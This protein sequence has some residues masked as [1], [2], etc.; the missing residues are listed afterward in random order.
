MALVAERLV[1]RKPELAMFDQALTDLERGG[2]V[3]IEVVGEPGIGKTRLLSE[4][5]RTADA[6][7]QLVLSGSA[8][9]LESDVPFW[10]FVDALDE[11]VHGLKPHRVAALADTTRAELAT[12]FPS[13]SAPATHP[14]VALQHERYRSHRAVRE[15]LERLAD[16]Q[17]LVLLLDDVHWAD[18]ASLELLGALL[19]RPPSAPVLIVV[20]LRPRQVPDRLSVPI[21]RAERAGTLARAE[22]APLSRA[23]ARE[24]LSD[25]PD[26]LGAVLYD[27]SG[28]NPFYL[29]QLARSLDRPAEPS[30]ARITTV[31]EIDVPGSVAA[32]LAEELS[33]LSE[34]ARIVLQG[35]AVAGDPLEPEL[36]AAAADVPD[37]AALEAMNELLQRDLVRSTDVPRQFR[38]RHP[39][40][41]RAVYE[42]APGGWRIA[43][44]ERSARALAAL[45]A[46]AAARAHH[47]EYSAHTG[48]L[49]AVAVLREAGESAAHRAPASAERWFGAALRLLPDAAPAADRVELLLARSQSLAATGH[50][51]DSYAALLES[52]TIVP[53]ESVGLRVQVTTACAVVENLLGRH[54][55]AR[56]RLEDTLAEIG[57][58]ASPD[59][60]ALMIELAVDALFSAEYEAMHAWALRAADAAAPLGDRVL[61]AAT[62][63]VRA[64]GAAL[65][66]AVV[67][68]RVY[69]E[70][71]AELVDRL[72][73]DELSRRL[74]VLFHLANAEMYLDHF[75]DVCRHTDRALRIGRATGQGD[76][77][78]ILLPMLGTALWLQ[79]RVAESSDVLDGAVEAA[80]LVDNPHGLVWNLLSRSLAGFAAGDVD[81]ALA[82]GEEA[83]DVARRLDAST[84]SAWAAVAL[85]TAQ[86]GTD[87]AARATELLIASGGI[88][89]QQIGG[90]WR[91]R[92][93]ELL[94]RCLLASGRH[95][96]AQRTASTAADCADGI[97]L[98]MAAAMAD[99]ARAVVM[100]DAGDSGDAAERALLAATALE[101]VGNL[102]DAAGAR[103]LAGRALARAGE[104]D[105]AATQLERSAAAFDGF[106]SPRLRAEAERELRKLGR[107]IHRR[108]RAGDADATGVASLTGRELEVGRLVADGKTNAEI[109]AALYLSPKTVE[110]HLRNTFRKLNV[111]SRL[112]VARA[113]EQ[114]D[115]AGQTT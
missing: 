9:E 105:Q 91:V 41:R 101:E 102:F 44:H 93:L 4:L 8:S 81:V 110:T 35:A 45:G 63:A 22:V 103:T 76:L 13:L 96:E 51:A 106:G 84:A 97:S 92:S 109:A 72:S 83:V 66:G 85:A 60:I 3:A 82:T 30:P 98:P 42:S 62:L 38:F 10:L 39:L 7:G 64:A 19:H 26:E 115:H 100:L 56:A 36:A 88:D 78:P 89:Q 52:L 23:E 59:A 67:N 50:F 47:V 87:R 1:G 20:A 46:S 40:L 113:V 5:G 104:H 27:E 65:G 107:R 16:T 95:E 6:R 69:R 112:Q 80:R 28:G 34:R 75:E 71:A 43:A 12:V 29:E 2:S 108:T 90:G 86:L 32:A 73:D 24:L 79:G 14:E 99:L 53:E 49:A 94:T 70:Q 58:A 31:A 77:F 61:G 17:P 54:K 11:Y 57:D 33:L 15:L 48:D 111:S 25:S 37:A 74:D 18:P 68:A 55:Q 21:A 114:S